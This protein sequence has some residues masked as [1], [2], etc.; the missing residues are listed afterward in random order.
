MMV[1]RTKNFW[2][3]T[4]CSVVDG[5]QRSEATCCLDLCD[6]R[7]VWQVSPK[8]C[9]QATKHLEDP[10]RSSQ[11]SEYSPG[12]TIRGSN[13][14]RDKGLSLPQLVVTGSAVH[15]AYYSN[16]TAFLSRG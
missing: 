15:P 14:G 6:R 3:V 4:P 13:S 16:G 2:K 10:G 1:V 9:Y 12:W 11:S 8:R 5:Y 7:W